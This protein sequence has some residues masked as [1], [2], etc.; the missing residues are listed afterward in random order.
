MGTQV[1]PSRRQITV[2]IP[3]GGSY[4]EELSKRLTKL[5]ISHNALARQMGVA[6]SQVSRWFNR[7][8]MTPHMENIAKIEKAIYEICLNR[9]KH[10]K[11]R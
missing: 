7:P 8:N 9:E 10:K 5:E 11:R 2:T 6:P 4:V 3:V 1:M